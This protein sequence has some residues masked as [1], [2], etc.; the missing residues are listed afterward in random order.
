M[1]S[2]FDLNA[3]I[4]DFLS[5]SKT[6]SGRLN[7][8]AATVIDIF[9]SQGLPNLIGGSAGEAG[10]RGIVRN[11]DWD[12]AFLFAGKPRL[13]ISLKSILK[14]VSGT[15]PNR[16]DDL[17]GEVANVQQFSPEVVTGYVIV[18]DENANRQRRDGIDWFSYV[19]QSL[20]KLAIRKAP[21]WNQGLIEGF[22]TI[23]IDSRLP[24]GQRLVNPEKAMA[25][26]AVFASAL[27]SELRRREPAIFE[28]RSST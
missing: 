25:D 20:K 22:W 19:E 24:L 28:E 9:A 3:A 13:L 18:L 7:A 4:N 6:D 11:K 23:R 21:L 8:L 27:I 14:N 10:I 16:L 15:V 1:A 17:M 12:L 2:E 26:G 5:R